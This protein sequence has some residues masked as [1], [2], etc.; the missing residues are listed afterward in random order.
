MRATLF[1]LA[2]TLVPSFAL[3]QPR[4]IALDSGRSLYDLV[5]E[6]GARTL[7]STVSVAVTCSGLAYDCAANRLWMAST[8]SDSLYSLDATTG[9]ATLIGPF[10]DTAIVMHGLEW[11]ASTQTLYGASSHNGGLYTINPTTGA[12]TLVGLT[13]LSS[14][15]NLGWDSTNNVMY[16]TNSSTDSFYTINRTT[17][18]ATL[19]G[20]LG[21]P[22]NPHGL[23]YRRDNDTLFLICSNTDTLYTINRATGSTTV[24]GAPGSG[25]YL[26]LAWIVPCGTQAC[27]RSDVAGANQSVGADGNLT[28]DDI[29]VFLGWFFANDT[30]ADVAG[31]NQSTTPDTLLTADDIIV[32]LGRFFA[33]C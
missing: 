13:G 8:S 22:T 17:G 18:A 32:F 15:T 31:A 19:I 25:N 26:G 16:A 11:D 21:G 4:L 30:R 20:P 1:C 27:G 2:A 6:S 33:G 5:P 29:I 23:A 10:G 9:T 24:I 28:A 7:I 14:F 3:A 12:A